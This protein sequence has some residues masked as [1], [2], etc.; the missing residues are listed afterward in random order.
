[1]KR[2]ASERVAA[3]EAP[4]STGRRA[5][6]HE[7]IFEAN[8]RAGRIFDLVL[9]W[10]ILLSVATVILESVRSV[11][12]RYGDLL[13]ALEWFFTLLF[14]AEYV[15]RLVSVR[16][17]LRYA[18]S[19]FGVVDLL[20]IIP[21]YLSIF[22]PGSQYL[23]VIRI[24]RLL[25]VFRLLK[26]SE[27]VE[28]ADTLRRALRASSRKISV[29]ISAVL[30]LVVIIGA[31]MYVIEGEAHGFTSI[32]ISIYWAIVTLTTVGYG[33]LSPR[34]PFGQIL[35]SVVMVIGYGIIAVPTGIVSVELAQATRQRKMAK[36]ACP[37]CGAEGHDPDA[38]C[39]KH[40]GAR[41]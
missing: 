18:T 28:E 20:A 36:Q 33:D 30:L 22:V 9:I 15:L 35:A 11:R 5:R 13:Y 12:V 34:T 16:R 24:L 2:Q 14:T 37:A 40:C 25:R 39:C 1:M 32:P 17:P 4:S 3:T 8:T 29:F 21:T 19:F 27:Y 6:L 26:L 10:L 7:I 31:L 38:L 23:L 41:L